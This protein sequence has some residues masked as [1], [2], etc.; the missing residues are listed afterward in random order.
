MSATEL[1][2]PIVEE[3]ANRWGFFRLINAGR[4]TPLRLNQECLEGLSFYGEPLTLSDC[5]G[6]LGLQGGDGE[7]AFPLTIP[8]E[9]AP[10]WRQQTRD[11]F[12]LL[13]QENPRELGREEARR[14]QKPRTPAGELSEELTCS[15]EFLRRT[16]QGEFLVREKKPIVADYRRCQGNYLASV[17]SAGPVPKMLLMDAS[18]Q[19]ASHLLGFNGAPLRGVVCHPQSFQNLDYRYDELPAE[20]ALRFT[21]KRW[22]PE[23]LKY[24]AWCNSGTEAWE[25]ALH[26]AAIKFPERGPKCVCF[27][28]SFHGRSLLSLFSSWN[29]V[30]REPFQL[31]G[32]ETLWADF[33]EDKEPHFEKRATEDWLEIWED[34]YAR[35]WEPP[36]VDPDRDPLLAAELES[37]LQ[38]REHLRSGRVCAVSVEPMQCEGGDRYASHR[39][40]QALRVLTFAH[41]VALIFDEVQTGFGL[42]GAPLWSNI[43]DLQDSDEDPLPPD[44]IVLAKKCQVG[45]VLSSIEDPYRTSA[46]AASF[47][48][49]YSNAAA[50]NEDLLT[51][52]GDTVRE[53]L[54]ELAVDYDQLQNPRAQGLAFAFDLPSNAHANNFV[55]QRFY[56]GIMVYIAGEHTL[57]FRIQRTTTEKDLDVIFDAIRASL[58][59]LAVEGPEVLPER[60]DCDW[61]AE[62]EAPTHP[63]PADIKELGQADWPSILRLFGE[64]EPERYQ[65]LADV[66]E[67]RPIERFGD[68][69]RQRKLTWLEFLRFMAANQATRIVPLN[70]D[71]WDQH[72]DAIMELERKVYEP[73]RVDSEEFLAEAV[74]AQGAVALVALAEEKLM[75]FCIGAPLEN[76]SQVRGPDNDPDLGTGKL[77]Y[78]ADLLVDPVAQGQ[79]LGQRLKARQ[80][81]EVRRMGYL[82]VRSRN[83]VGAADS[84]RR[85]NRRFGGAERA[86]FENDYGEDGA[87][88]VYLG[89]PLLDQAEPKLVWSS[90]VEN[91]TG[92]LLP[93]EAWQDWDLAAINKNSL[94]NWW[95]P[96]MTRYVEWLRA[97]APLPHLY[98][99]SGRDEAVDKLVKCLIHHR[100]GA[101][102]MV[103]FEGSF[104]GGVTGCARSLSDAHFG[105]YFEWERLPFPYSEGD[106]FAGMDEALTDP[107]MDCFERLS[108]LFAEGQEYLGLA[109]EPVQQM[110][111][112]RLSVRFLQA[113]RS[114]CDDNDVPLVM[115][116]SAAWAYRGS[117]E[118]FYCQ[119]TGVMPDLLTFFG[120]GQLGHVLVSD[121]YF[122]PKPLQLIS[123]WDGDELS[124]L[125]LREQIR[126][127]KQ[128]R[129]SPRLHQLDLLVGDR[130]DTYRGSGRLYQRQ[131]GLAAASTIDKKGQLLF[132][133][134]NRIDEGWRNLVKCLPREI[135]GA[136]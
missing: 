76:F 6:Y 114:V 113:L 34:S 60:P 21:L 72:K 73:A 18:S 84:M 39:F 67:G 108:E 125:R 24:I 121:R 77:F 124:A 15:A 74:Q 107:E 105:G 55:N 95:T 2:A 56:R 48:R 62:Q 127:L 129:D 96:N 99:A 119:A 19:I 8:S 75:G 93:S 130:G 32:H 63:V 64:L 78:S 131:T 100:R 126:I 40:F 59:H 35:E 70:G 20:E 49:G 65:E 122:I 7:L 53:R 38:V 103:T 89:T 102:K 87:A 118:L 117:R 28:G 112:R 17:D 66:L 42:G 41:G 83:R 115:N 79:G 94:C 98:L 26:L 97:E 109:V 133:P 11:F 71:N 132:P 50:V 104:W 10:R 22:A 43:F 135:A 37:L 57:R 61:D 33:P 120:G 69:H 92:G 9:E 81:R 4:A 101:Q 3:I 91:P 111:G 86:F 14:W 51:E 36:K 52:L 23:S 25:K 44:F 80:L 128:Y 47:M 5:A 110:T 30:K 82:G 29:P 116:E 85:L 27:R 46:H 12:D 16:Y 88:C 58:R 134:L 45:A 54:F 31:E 106:P 136:L 123:T 68:L 13:A 1:L 90:G